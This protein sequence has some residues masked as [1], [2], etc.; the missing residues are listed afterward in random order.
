MDKVGWITNL[1]KGNQTRRSL[2]TK[3]WLDILNEQ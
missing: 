3:Q 2:E 1:E